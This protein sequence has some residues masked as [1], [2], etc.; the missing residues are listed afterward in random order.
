MSH[1][2]A[3]LRVSRPAILGL[4]VATALFTAGC[5]G[6]D[7]APEAEEGPVSESVAVPTP[8]EAGVPS[9]TEETTGETGSGDVDALVA[10]LE[11]C[12]AEA[13][14]E[15]ETEV[16]DLATYDEEAVIDLTFEYG[17]L[18][19]PGAVTIYVFATE[20]AAAK[21]KKAIDEDLLEGDSEALLRGQLV[22]DDFGTTLQEPE[23]AEQAEVV[24]SCTA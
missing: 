13:G 3:R 21:A 17:G 15:S 1:L 5:G 20:E 19:V 4:V 2:I 11:S 9:P 8:T 7:E 18:T 12:F 24:D 6:D 16:P 14:I 10:E 22:V 23:A